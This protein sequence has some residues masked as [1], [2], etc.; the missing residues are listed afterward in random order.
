MMRLMPPQSDVN[1]DWLAYNTE[2]ANL[3][4]FRF[5]SIIRNSHLFFLSFREEFCPS[6]Q[7]SLGI[8][9]K[10]VHEGEINLLLNKL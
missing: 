7:E 10:N 1:S 6:L 4:F 2:M 8:K 3:I 9:N 5:T